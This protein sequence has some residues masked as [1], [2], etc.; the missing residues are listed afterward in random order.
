MLESGEPDCRERYVKR[1]EE[2]WDRRK[3]IP[4]REDRTTAY[5]TVRE[6]REPRALFELSLIVPV[7][8]LLK[9]GTTP[10]FGKT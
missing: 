4:L 3:E 9:S 5:R 6:W 10:A 7:V 8:P 2:H 1:S